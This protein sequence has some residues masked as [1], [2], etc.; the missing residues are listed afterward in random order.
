M[1]I[2]RQAVESTLFQRSVQDGICSLTAALPEHHA[3]YFVQ[4]LGQV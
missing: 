4:I 2:Q 1:L 3:Y